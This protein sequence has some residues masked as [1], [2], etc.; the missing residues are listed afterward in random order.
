MRLGAE[1]ARDFSQTT[2]VLEHAGMLEDTS[3][4]GWIAWREGMG[5]LANCPNIH[6]KLSGLG[7]FTRR[8]AVE[9]MRPILRETI[10]LFGPDRCLWG[11]N[12]PIEKLWTSYAA[13]VENIRA[14]L[15]D[16]PPS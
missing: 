10:D 6:V 1:L 5:L 4:A 2:I 8:S 7:T 16:F 3:S 11:S 14:G 13:L 9:D 15:A 12:F